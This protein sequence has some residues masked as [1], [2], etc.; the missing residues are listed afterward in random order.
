MLLGMFYIQKYDFDFLETGL[1]YWNR[2]N[3]KT[4]EVRAS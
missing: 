3:K 1:I 2:D 4:L